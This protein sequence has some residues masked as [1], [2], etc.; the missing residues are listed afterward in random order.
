MH[1]AIEGASYLAASLC[2]QRLDNFAV[3]VGD[4]HAVILRAEL[5]VL[6]SRCP[7]VRRHLKAPEAYWQRNIFPL[8]NHGDD[9]VLSLQLRLFGLAI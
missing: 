8:K 2:N 6:V 3:F 7:G 1:E 5:A 9:L 4:V